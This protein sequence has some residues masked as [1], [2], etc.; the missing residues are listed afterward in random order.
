M[1]RIDKKIKIISDGW[2]F[3]ENGRKFKVDIYNNKGK[4]VAFVP[5]WVKT[6]VEG[7]VELGRDL[8][9]PDEE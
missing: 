6:P 7:W 1:P 5:I 9:M 2:Y 8:D 3:D 4:R